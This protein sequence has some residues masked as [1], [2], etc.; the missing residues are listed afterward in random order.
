ML[1]KGQ[2]TPIALTGLLRRLHVAQPR[3]R[4]LISARGTDQEDDLLAEHLGVDEQPIEVPPL[5]DDQSMAYLIE[6]LHVGA[7]SSSTRWSTRPRAR[8]GSWRWLPTSWRATGT[9]PSRRSA[10][11]T[12][13][14]PGPSTA[15]SPGST[16]RASAAV[17]RYGCLANWLTREIVEE[18]VLPTIE[19]VLTHPGLDDVSQDSFPSSGHV[20]VFPTAIDL[21]PVDELWNSLLR[22]GRIPCGR[23]SP[24]QKGQK[25]RQCGSPTSCAHRSTPCWRS[26][27]EAGSCTSGCG[28]STRDEHALV[29]RGGSATSGRRSTT[30]A[31]SGR[32]TPRRRGGTPQRRRERPTAP[33]GRQH[34]RRTWSSTTTRSYNRHRPGT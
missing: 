2:R 27:R 5:E 7:R 10:V 26:V 25:G 13:S 4:L 17:V 6:V 24:R 23:G 33:T 15:S 32:P 34:W 14:S 28:S 20:A 21:P 12:S 19:D 22:F 8:C 11:S 16:S 1:L 9:S 29:T 3:I 18:V 31:A 30:A